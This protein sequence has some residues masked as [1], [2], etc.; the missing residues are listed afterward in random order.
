[1]LAI[2]FFGIP[3]SQYYIDPDE[4]ES[5]CNQILSAI[6]DF[7]PS[8]LIS[9]YKNYKEEKKDALTHS[10]SAPGAAHDSGGYEMSN[11][12]SQARL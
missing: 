7:S 12:D 3:R 10:S 6:I 5:S 2:A 9:A 8:G 1:M 11:I 4:K